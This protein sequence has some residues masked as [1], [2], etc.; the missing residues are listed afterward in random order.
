M[1]LESMLKELCKENLLK[2]SEYIKAKTIEQKVIRFINEQDLI[3]AGDK[4]LIALSGGPDSVFL[5]HF[6]NKFKK[7]YRIEIGS[8]HVNHILR[9]KD[10]DRDELFC[11]SICNELGIPFYSLRKNVKTFALKNKLSLEV[12]GRKIRYDF[13][14]K[15]AIKN[16]FNK[17]ATAHNAD[18]NIETIFLNLIKGAGIKGIAGIPV[19]RENIIRPIGC[20]TKTEILTYLDANHYEFRIDASNLS[21]EFERNFLRNQII[22][23]IK[24]KL[25]PA[26]DRAVLKTAINLQHLVSELDTKSYHLEN[27]I[28]IKENNY[29]VLPLSLFSSGTKGLSSLIIK[30]KIEENFKAK[31]GFS[32]IK[33]IFLLA[34]RQPGKSEQLTN[35]LVVMRERDKLLIKKN[36]DSQIVNVIKFKVGESI[37]IDGK[38]LSIR[39]TSID[40]INIG[41][42]KNVEYIDAEKIA[43]SFIVRS[44][45]PGD[46]FHPIG[47]KGTKKISD[48]LNDIKVSPFEKEKQ[49]VLENREKIVWV[50]GK[51]IDDRFKI[52]NNTKKALEL[53]L[54]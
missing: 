45:K 22:P 23:L 35:S 4:I 31:I 6:L 53:C 29:L 40:K 42:S 34:G 26:L 3:E 28:S 32:D 48:Y 15:V 13:F 10:S 37:K 12:A 5:L 36:P 52:T 39:K 38:I 44:W 47:M 41:K 17:I 20:L 27:N 30:D 11:K 50:I 8:V 19:K 1:Y 33:K 49:L 14:N 7:K 51:R 16:N 54:K 46:K 18:D 2:K 25:N 9:G 43:G 21:D 24:Q